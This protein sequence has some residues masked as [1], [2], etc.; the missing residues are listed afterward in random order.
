MELATG[1]IAVGLNN[2]SYN[3]LDVLRWK[4]EVI[5]PTEVSTTLQG[6][7]D[8]FLLRN[9]VKGREGRLTVDMFLNEYRNSNI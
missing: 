6:L 5:A 9:N 1:A 2:K 4:A 8:E 3:Y 7:T